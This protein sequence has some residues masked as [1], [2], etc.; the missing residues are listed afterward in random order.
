LRWDL[1]SRRV[2]PVG[3]RRRSGEVDVIYE[4]SFART[5]YQW[6]QRYTL[7]SARSAS[8]D[9]HKA[10][11]WL[12]RIEM[13]KIVPVACEEHASGFVGQ[14]KNGLVHRVPGKSLPQ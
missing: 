2:K 5:L 3:C 8:D 4:T 13:Q 1:N 10:M 11:M 12:D 14:P 9:N 7:I 6:Q